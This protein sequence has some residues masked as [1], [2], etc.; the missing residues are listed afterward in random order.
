MQFDQALNSPA[1]STVSRR[2]PVE[3]RG[4]DEAVAT[5]SCAEARPG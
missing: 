3:P 2:F 4:G 1:P 5:G